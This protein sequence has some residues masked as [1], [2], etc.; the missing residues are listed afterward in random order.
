MELI[1][2][3]SIYRVNETTSDL[4]IVGE[5]KFSNDIESFDGYITS[6]ASIDWADFKCEKINGGIIVTF[7]QG[8]YNNIKENAEIT[9]KEL[10]LNLQDSIL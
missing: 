1:Y 7:K 9:L 5:V 8:I 3:Y 4:N 6:K 2:K 10:F